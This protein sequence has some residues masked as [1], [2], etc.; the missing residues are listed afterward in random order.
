VVPEVFLQGD[1][2]LDEGGLGLVPAAAD[3]RQAARLILVEVALNGSARDAG[4]PGDEGVAEAV[5][6]EP[7]HLQLALDAGVGVVEA[8]MSDRRQVVLRKVE[9]AHG[10]CP[11]GSRHLRSIPIR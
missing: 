10:Q 6:L 9:S 2:M 4:Q 7:Q 5:A 3:A 1:G 11:M 8:A